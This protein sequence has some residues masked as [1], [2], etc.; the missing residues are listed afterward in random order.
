MRGSRHPPARLALAAD[1]LWARAKAGTLGVHDLELC[2][3]YQ[4]L[5]SNELQRVLWA[6]G[7]VRSGQ[8]LIVHLA[9]EIIARSHQGL[10]NVFWV[11]AT[12][13]QLTMVPN[14][15]RHAL[16]HLPF[17][18]CRD[19]AG[20]AW[21]YAVSSP[22]NRLGAK[23][24]KR[25]RERAWEMS[26]RELANV[27]WAFA[28]MEEPW[29]VAK[30]LERRHFEL[31]AREVAGL[32]WAA[33]KTQ[34]AMGL[35]TRALSFKASELVPQ[36]VACFIWA[37]AKLSSLTERWFPMAFHKLSELKARHIANMLWALA[38]TRLYCEPLLGL[39]SRALQ[40]RD[41]NHVELV[42]MAWSCARLD[43]IPV[44]GLEFSL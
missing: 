41:V 4:A 38:S 44:P 11:L 13:G 12:T 32:L 29:R 35:E 25:C 20:I 42:T 34:E 26:A 3:E 31:Q 24:A 21:A 6:V 33:A 5:S 15:E 18:K 30:W 16:R 28:K 40:Q 1:L 36:E 17:A 8:P 14:L 19:L 37:M 10:G 2:K 39:P 7:T 9:G 27:T 43:H 23:L 22:E